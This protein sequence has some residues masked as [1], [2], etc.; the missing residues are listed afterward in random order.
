MLVLLL[1]IRVAT[2]AELSIDSGA[3]QVGALGWD[4]VE[5][6]YRSGGSWSV[7]VDGVY[8]VDGP[9]LGDWSL[10]CPVD[11]VLAELGC[12]RGQL[13]WQQAGKSPLEAEFSAQRIDEHWHLEVLADGWRLGLEL[14]EDAP[15]AAQASLILDDF[16]LSSLPAAWL[17]ESG[18][19]L[20]EGRLS[21][22][23]QRHSTGALEFDLQLRALSLDTE[24]GLLAAEGL[25][26]DI[27]A[28]VTKLDDSP[29]F[30]GQIRQLGGEIL[31][32]SLYLPS[33]A[34]P[35]VLTLAGQRQG[36]DHW[37]LSSVRLIDP[38]AMTL[39]GQALLHAGADGWEL[40]TLELD[41][42]EASMPGFWE[43]W[44]DGLAAQSGFGDLQ[45]MGLIRGQS[46]WT[47]DQGWAAQAQIE[48]FDLQDPAG[49]LSLNGLSGTLNWQDQ[50][51]ETELSWQALAL[52]GL[53]FGSSTLRLARG[54]TGLELLEALELPL[55][56]GAI[57]I[58]RLDW[59]PGE[60]D[61]AGLRLDARI[62]PLSLTRLTRQLEWPEFGGLLSGEF[63][64]IV[65]ADEQLRFT[66]GIN[67]QAFSG[68]IAL[69]ELS[70]ERPF[71][72][73]PA[74]SA[75]VQISR[76]DLLELTGAFNFGRMEGEVSGWMRDLRLLDWR[77]VRMD[78]RFFT[79][80]DAQRRRISQRAVN[81]LSSLGGAGGAL[82][83]GTVMRV[84]EDFP[85]RRAG[86]ACRLA[87]NICHI[88]GVAPHESG[89]F[90]IVEGRA[91]PR[92]DIIG[93]RRL[94]DWPQLVS[95]LEA[96]LD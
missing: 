11:E 4:Q 82:I 51:S 90:F 52:Y 35:L 85:Y 25:D 96:M 20:L 88:D 1:L 78:A 72:T 63:P 48:H 9:A 38:G 13:A 79:H 68:T 65:Y 67:V 80:E 34:E 58:D 61:E 6:R 33:P 43:R 12:A 36:E 73:L 94:V 27:A 86:L 7:A 84:F 8:L 91:L 5:V 24:G 92:L 39:V 46:S 23:A 62:R 87:N 21:G 44:A 42:F 89:G 26:L 16:Q 2:A 93:H 74:V 15:A 60:S 77:P 75:Q 17:A 95:Q 41:S 19:T 49:R 47:A 28:T 70:I 66:G 83:T 30:S 59:Q 57:V 53:P 71:G 81:N 56:D 37:R 22:Q 40:A 3:G 69:D 14:A 10:T 55:L 18:L 31:A 64:G 45:T 50:G 54:E 76:L 32:G 29:D